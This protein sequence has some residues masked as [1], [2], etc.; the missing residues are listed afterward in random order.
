[1]IE[2]RTA[3]GP[4]SFPVTRDES[5]SGHIHSRASLLT[6]ACAKT[7]VDEGPWRRLG[8]H[9]DEQ[10]NTGVRLYD[11]LTLVDCGRSRTN[12][13]ANIAGETRMTRSPAAHFTR[14][15]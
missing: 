1:M 15:R 11:T 5:T 13:L 9:T 14:V 12:S 3:K 8:R 2:T 4:S 10:S 7:R 6:L